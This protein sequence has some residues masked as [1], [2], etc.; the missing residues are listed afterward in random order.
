MTIEEI[1]RR[2]VRAHLGILIVCL[3]A[4]LALVFV[5][6]SREEPVWVASVRVQAVDD[7]PVSTTEAEGISSRVLA[8][9][10]TPALVRQALLA[11]KVDR[12]AHHVAATQVAATRLG[13]STVV[14]LEVS[15]GDRD[16]AGR[17]AAALA[18]Q[19]TAFMNGGSQSHFRSVQTALES[20]IATATQN[21]DGLLDR[22]AAAADDRTRDT[23]RTRLQSAEDDLA[24]L[25]AQRASLTLADATRSRVVVIDGAAPEVHQAP[26]TLVP[27]L[28]LA[29][30]LGL[31]L[32]LTLAVLL[33]SVRPR[34]ASVRNVS[35]LLGA[36]LLSRTTP[37]SPP[38]LQAVT[39]AARRQGVDTVVLMGVEDRDSA[40]V[41]DLL[42]ELTRSAGR[43][44]PPRRPEPKPRERAAAQTGSKGGPRWP[45]EGS[46]APVNGQRHA[47]PTREIRFTVRV[48][49]QSTDEDRAGVLVVSSTT[50]LHARIDALQALVDGLRWP[51]VGVVPSDAHRGWGGR[52]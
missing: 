16:A 12:D 9:A 11:S 30:L 44:A 33:E 2:I 10:T 23:L 43:P 14:E 26:S 24:Q 34:L 51:V 32:G 31:F 21:R 19:V 37:G 47:S 6:Q 3:A 42:A 46:D 50:P 29:A 17:I 40:A 36:P 41:Q 8:L 7:A 48:G 49:L 20:D 35:R 39:L 38:L 45:S 22:L 28:A 25:N 1:F 13:E 27:Q 18:E 4:P 5:L 52:R 15:D